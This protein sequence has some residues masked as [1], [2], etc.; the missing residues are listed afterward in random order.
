MASGTIHNA[1]TAGLVRMNNAPATKPTS[2]ATG[3]ASMRKSA[4]VQSLS[5]LRRMTA[6]SANSIAVTVSPMSAAFHSERLEL[7]SV[8]KFAVIYSVA[9]SVFLGAE[10]GATDLRHHMAKRLLE[11]CLP[12]RSASRYFLA[13][14]IVR[15]LLFVAYRC[16]CYPPAYPIQLRQPCRGTIF[17]EPW[18]STR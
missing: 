18:R 6:K 14:N 17:L 2:A 16:V 3:V 8:F 11:P 4:T 12:D 9:K 10:L 7:C 15:P 5:L 13:P 1:S